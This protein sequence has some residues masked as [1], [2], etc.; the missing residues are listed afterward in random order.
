LKEETQQEILKVLDGLMRDLSAWLR[1]LGLSEEQAIAQFNAAMRENGIL[2]NLILNRVDDVLPVKRSGR[3]EPPQLE[4]ELA[5]FRSGEFADRLLR[6]SEPTAEEL[7]QIGSLK[8]VLADLRS[9]MQ[10]SAKGGPRHKT[11]G[12]PNV[13][14]DPAERAKIREMIRSLRGPGVRLQDLFQRMADR[15]GVSDTSIKRIWLEKTD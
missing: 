10:D 3:T 5:L 8:N 9:R 6:Q 4:Q 12:R 7:D 11:G 14:E 1:Q 13:L 2:A 15:Y